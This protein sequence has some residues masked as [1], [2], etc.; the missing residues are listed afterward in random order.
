MAND[1]V[2]ETFARLIE[3]V[4]NRFLKGEV[5]LSDLL[6]LTDKEIE[7]I[8]LMGHYLYNYGK[9]ASA[10]S[11]FSVLTVYKPF[12]SKYWRAAGAANQALKKYEEA[13]TAYD[14]ALSIYFS[15]TISYTYRGECYLSMG[16][17]SEG[18]DDLRRAVE[19]GAGNP[20]VQHWVTRARTLL[21]V[22]GVKI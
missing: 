18:I 15:D 22:R 16:R 1:S 19:V 9:Y 3:H 13:V 10:L 5:T 11:V 2:A 21:D 8:F 14:M 7:V 6:D 4:A 12:I 20:V 17:K